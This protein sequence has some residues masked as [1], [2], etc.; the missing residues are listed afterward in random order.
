M[1]GKRVEGKGEG[2]MKKID[3]VLG[4]IEDVIGGEK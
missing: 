2:V 3:V 4:E 1:W